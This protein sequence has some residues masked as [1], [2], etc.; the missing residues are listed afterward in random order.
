MSY[1]S[2]QSLSE[3]MKYIYFSHRGRISSST[4]ITYVAFLFFL[5]AISYFILLP[6]CVFLPTAMKLLAI[7]GYVVALTY[8]TFML[9]VKRLHDLNHS[10]WFSLILYLPVVNFFLLLYLAFRRGLPVE[11][12]FGYP[13]S[14]QPSRLF[15]IAGYLTFTA[16]MLAMA[17]QILLLPLFFLKPPAEINKSSSSIQ[18]P[19]QTK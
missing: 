10:G 18:E 2:E 9:F 14:Y 13:S 19:T 5:S 6:I 11:N 4:F 1:F 16:I 12:Q 8:S 15:S 3:T 17:I 7:I